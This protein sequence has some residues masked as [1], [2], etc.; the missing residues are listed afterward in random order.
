MEGVSPTS[1]VQILSPDHFNIATRRRNPQNLRHYHWRGLTQ[2]GA[3]FHAVRNDSRHSALPRAARILDVSSASRKLSSDH[4]CLVI[5]YKVGAEN[6][7]GMK[8][9][10]SLRPSRPGRAEGHSC[11]RPL[12]GGTLLPVVDCGTGVLLALRIGSCDGDCAGLAV[13]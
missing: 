11:C 5:L 4:L 6:L 9:K 3:E 13:G 7:E 1:K 8:M 12:S 10:P 2:A